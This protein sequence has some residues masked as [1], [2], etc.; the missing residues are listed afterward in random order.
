MSCELCSFVDELE[1]INDIKFTLK[2]IDVISALINGKSIK[3]IAALLNLSPKTVETLLRNIKQ[4]L[5]CSSKETV[6]DFIENSNKYL[7]FNKHYTNLLINA[8]FERLL[9]KI[10]KIGQ[11]IAV[12]CSNVCNKVIQHLS[13]CNIKINDNSNIIFNCNVKDY[14][15]D[16]LDLIQ[17]LKQDIKIDKQIEEFEINRSRFYDTYIKK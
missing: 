5:N 16:F 10:G 17:K 2:E 11:E 3:S 6:I 8:E 7:L 14:Y 12:K 9:N 13:I 15:L 4:K 1:I